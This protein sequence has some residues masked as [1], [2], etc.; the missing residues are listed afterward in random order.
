MEKDTQRTRH[1]LII[2]DE[3][4][5]RFA[6]RM[7]LEKMNYNVI[8]AEDALEAYGMI[9]RYL[10]EGPVL[11]F[12]LLDLYLP[13]MSGMELIDRLQSDDIRIPL[14]ITSGFLT[15]AVRKKL[16]QRHQQYI[17]SKPFRPKELIELVNEMIQPIEGG[18]DVS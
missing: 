10:Q 13:S 5:T 2:E 16:A 12:I 14:L 11:D 9:H 7:T 1:C 17:L 6:F 15:A 3:V 8:E 4:Q 18:E